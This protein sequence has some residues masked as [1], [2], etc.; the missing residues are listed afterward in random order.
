MEG[1]MKFS[2][3]TSKICISFRVLGISAPVEGGVG[4]REGIL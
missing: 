3:S 2:D 4:S 1:E